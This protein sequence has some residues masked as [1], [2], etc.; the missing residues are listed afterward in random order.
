M[1]KK[2]KI[3]SV[4]IPLY[5]EEKTIFDVIKQVQNADIKDVKKEII[6]VDDGSKD[7]SVKSA[8][9][10]EKK[11]DNVKVFMHQKNQGKGGAIRTAI[12]H[13]TGD[14]III[15]DADLE[16]EPNEYWSLI[17]PILDKKAQVVYGSRRLKKQK[18]Y[19][20][21]GFLFFFGGNALTVAANLLFNAHITDEATCYKVFDATVLKG[22]KLDCK[23]FEFCPEVTAKVAKK[24]IKI[25]EVPISYYP[26][27][28]EEGKKIRWKDGFEAIWT[29]LKYRF[30]N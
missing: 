30:V 6:I 22:I 18:Q 8:K 23:R 7:D 13:A 16:Y 3:L 20:Q 27:S 5:N 9:K 24:G 29:L 14:I 25:L 17:K 21:K 12:S 10:I 11:Y 19:Q 26:R 4:L 28:I 1:E 15:Q 2:Q